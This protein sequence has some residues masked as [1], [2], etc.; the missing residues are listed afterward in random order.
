VREGQELGTIRLEQVEP[1]QASG[2]IVARREGAVIYVGDRVEGI[3]AAMPSAPR[4]EALPAPSA[5]R[6][7]ALPAPSAPRGG[8]A[9]GGFTGLIRVPVAEVVPDRYFTV[10]VSRDWTRPRGCTS[11]CPQPARFAEQKKSIYQ[12]TMGFLPHLEIGVGLTELPNVPPSVTG[13]FQDR[14][15]RAQLVFPRR[16]GPGPDVAVGSTDLIG[17]RRFASDYLVASQR[18]DQ[19]G[20]HLGYGRGELDG[21]FGGLD[22][23]LNPQVQGLVEYDT[24]GLNVGVRYAPNEKVSVG[25]AW[26]NGED[27]GY[28]LHYT[29]GLTTGFH[30]PRSAARGPLVRRENAGSGPEACLDELQAA[31]VRHGFENVRVGFGDNHLVVEYENR[32]YGRA[33]L[34]ALRA[35]LTQA[36]TLAPAAAESLSVIVKKQELPIL[37]LTLGIDDYLRF[38]NGELAAPAFRQRLAIT[39]EV[40]VPAPVERRAQGAGRRAQG[41]PSR[42]RADLA[43]RPGFGIEFG[44]RTEPLKGSLI[45]DLLVPLGR[46]LKATARTELVLHNTL[47]DQESWEWTRHT[48]SQAFRWPGNVYTQ[49]HLG[50]FTRDRVG[51]AQ[52]V[53]A[54]F[55]GGRTTGGLT[56]TWTG[57]SLSQLTDR[58]YGVDLQTRLPRLDVTTGVRYERFLGGERGVTFEVGRRFGDTEVG[59]FATKTGSGSLGGFRLAVPLVGERQPLPSDL[60]LKVGE[61]FGFAYRGR[62]FGRSLAG[63]GESV[64]VGDTIEQDLLDRDRLWADYLYTHLEELR[65]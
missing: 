56:A 64:N 54:R 46:G 44:Q 11:G 62:S 24:D 53:L 26:L 57:A 14:S 38:A 33:E 63:L 15:I 1:D 20:V 6:G 30:R 5:P 58:T 45:P 34:P 17:T 16:A 49:T 18:V 27:W 25:L 52:E 48:L 7:E 4:G 29:T 50:R 36:V 2:R 40:K 21:F 42:F 39:E 13:T 28:S 61:Y 23:P 51:L 9:L 43:L 41:N 32:V 35:V 19:V 37:R 31:L 3:G 59:F 10:G 8:R 65:E 55:D 22:R 60:R 12:L 47:D